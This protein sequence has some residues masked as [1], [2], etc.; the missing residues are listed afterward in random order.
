MLSYLRRNFWSRRSLGQRVLLSFIF[1]IAVVALCYASAVITTLEYTERGLMTRVMHEE[2][3]RSETALQAGFAPRL[4]NGY[5]LYGNLEAGSGEPLL[6]PLPAYAIDAP[7][8][9]SEFE[10]S[11]VVFLMKETRGGN[12]YAL[13]L[14]QQA[15][16]NEEQR[17]EIFIILSVIGVVIV[18]AAVGG[19]MARAVLRPVEELSA[20]VRVQSQADRYVPL[21]VAIPDDE[22]GELARLCNRAVRDL[23]EALEREKAFTGDVSHEL[24]TPL[25]IIRTSAELLELSVQTEKERALVARILEASESMKDLVTLFLELARNEH[26]TNGASGVKATAPGNGVELP[27]EHRPDNRGATLGHVVG[28]LRRHWAQRAEA[29]GLAFAE[30]GFDRHSAAPATEP[31]YPALYLQ[32]VLGNL[33]RNAVAYTE[34]GLVML[35]A[36]PS[37]CLVVDTGPGVS[38]NDAPHIF[39]AYRRGSAGTKAAG[40]GAE[41]SE[42]IGLGLSIA[43]RLARRCGWELSLRA[44]EELASLSKEA[45]ERIAE[46][47]KTEKV[48]VGAIFELRLVGT[49]RRR[50]DETDSAH[51]H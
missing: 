48:S 43:A 22:V 7:E 23:H 35:V 10:E 9:F 29:K 39:E 20:A 41:G 8:G 21:P 46:A 18:A 45:A 37:G 11:P 12:V 24:R 50:L 30:V 2:I 40:E 27:L 4:P 44:P 17:I 36:T 31:R 33:L 1:F 19:S 51:S 26:A 28:E 3:S 32:T 34:S 49:E 6:D 16:E 15:F 42:G 5:R 25:T 13:E 47:G 14:D 38:K